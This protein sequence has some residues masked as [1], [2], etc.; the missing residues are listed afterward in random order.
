MDD[1]AEAYQT[2]VGVIGAWMFI[3]FLL[4][5]AARVLIYAPPMPIPA[6]T[7]PTATTAPIEEAAQAEPAP[8]PTQLVQA[9]DGPTAD[10]QILPA[11]MPAGVTQGDLSL[12]VYQG[13]PWRFGGRSGDHCM[14]E[15]WP[16]GRGPRE[17]VWIMCVLLNL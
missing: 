2:N 12:T 17:Q 8:A 9:D 10:A 5:L 16:S 6:Q 11:T 14:I 3:V 1:Q 15:V 7:V 13:W 4:F